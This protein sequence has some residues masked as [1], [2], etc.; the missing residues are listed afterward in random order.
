MPVMRWLQRVEHKDCM[1]EELPLSRSLDDITLDWKLAL[2]L[3]GMV[4]VELKRYLVVKKEAFASQ[5]KRGVG[6]EIALEIYRFLSTSPMS[7][8]HDERLGPPHG[9][10]GKNKAATFNIRE[11][12]KWRAKFLCG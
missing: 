7:S 4:T 9:G 10:R 8:R 11:W 5:G 6:R 3:A 2:V 1:F 12:P